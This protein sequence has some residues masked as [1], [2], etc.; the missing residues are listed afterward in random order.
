M[1]GCETSSQLW[2]KLE[3]FFASRTR[4]KTKSAKKIQFKN[5]MKTGSIND[6]TEYMSSV[7]KIVDMLAA[8]G[9]PIK[10]V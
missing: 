3:L 5:K 9:P 10:Q 1:I 2:L 6:Y 8:V 7:K 4:A